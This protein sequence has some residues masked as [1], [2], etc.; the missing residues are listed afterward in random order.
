MLTYY[1]LHREVCKFAN[2]LTSL[3]VGKGDRVTIYLPMIPE[4]VISMLACARI[5]AVHTVVFGGFSADSLRERIADSGSKLL[6]TAD[7]GW[8]RG[9]RVALKDAAD[10][11]LEGQT[12]VEKVVVVNRTDDAKHVPM[13][14]TRDFWWHRLMEDAPTQARRPGNG[15]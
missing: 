12:T 6:I 5:G 14:Q 3:G 4:A 11:A 8:R 1:D 13:H 9:N 2:V 10:K 15:R 7:G